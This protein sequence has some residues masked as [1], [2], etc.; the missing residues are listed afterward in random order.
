MDGPVYFLTIH[1]GSQSFILDD[2]F[3]AYDFLADGEIVK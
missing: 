1:F 3:Q 2:L